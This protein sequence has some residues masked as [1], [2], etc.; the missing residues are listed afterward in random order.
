MAVK[1]T[2]Q[3]HGVGKTLVQFA[4]KTAAERSYQRIELHAREVALSFYKK[5]AYRIRGSQFMEVGIP[6][7]LMEKKLDK[8]VINTPIHIPKLEL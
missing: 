6:H 8:K 3:G 7:Y 5:L 2:W 1:E 4:E